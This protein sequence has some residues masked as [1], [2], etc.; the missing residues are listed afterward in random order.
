MTTTTLQDPPCDL[1]YLRL[2]A[3]ECGDCLEW[4]ATVSKE[5]YPII[6][7]RV[8]QPGQ[9]AKVQKQY[10]VRH[11]VYWLKHGRPVPLDRRFSLVTTCRNKLC[12]APDHV[13][14]WSKTRINKQSR[15]KGAWQSTAFAAKVAITLRRK[16]RLSDESVARIRTHEGALR[17]LADE[18]QISLA[19]AYMIRR[20]KCRRDYSNPFSQL[21]AGAGQP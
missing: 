10:Y 9:A 6:N 19:Y 2:R 3:T 20:G 1:S 5:G 7:L 14:R 12:I 21:L 16:S 17:E 15:A 13:E 8:P 18:L 11:L 4:R